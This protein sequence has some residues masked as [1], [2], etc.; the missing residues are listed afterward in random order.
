MTSAD[1]DCAGPDPDAPLVL[2]AGAG[3]HAACRA[4]VDRYLTRVHRLALRVLGHVDDANEVAQ[5]TFLRV[6]QHAARWQPGATRFSTW[7]FRIAHNLCMDTIR[8]R[9]PHDADALETLGDEGAGAATHEREATVAS[10]RA[11]VAALP[12]RQRAA[13]ALCHFEQLTNIEAAAA[14]DVSVEALESLLAR[15]RRTLRERLGPHS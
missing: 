5:E 2:R 10:V 13:L 15:A 9:R 8:R 11:A 14:M 1:E 3:D 12:A 4:L 6:W 7:L